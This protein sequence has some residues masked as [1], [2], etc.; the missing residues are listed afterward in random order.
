MHKIALVLLKIAKIA[1]RLRPQ[2]P[3]VLRWLGAPPPDPPLR[4]RYYAT[5]CSD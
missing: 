2:T 1:Q 5:A 4:N 3:N